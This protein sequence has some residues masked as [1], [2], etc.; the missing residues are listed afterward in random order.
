[1]DEKNLQMIRVLTNQVRWNEEMA[2]KGRQMYHFNCKM[3]E[4]SFQ[5]PKQMRKL[6]LY[7]LLG[8]EDDS[9][10]FTQYATHFLR[11][12]TPN[13]KSVFDLNNWIDIVN[14]FPPGTPLK[15]RKYGKIETFLG[16]CFYTNPL[17]PNILI[18]SPRV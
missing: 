9:C 6:T 17:P 4:P 2:E 10:K 8:L 11:S 15:S 18:P 3:F 13:I 14:Q 1:M 12:L 16:V 7:F 5:P